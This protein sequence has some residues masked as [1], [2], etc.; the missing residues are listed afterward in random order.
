MTPVS[1]VVELLKSLEK[2]TEAENKAEETLYKKF[3]CWAK[4]VIDT[5]TSTNAAA[6]ERIT[7]LET[8]I[9]D[10]EA[11][12]SEFTSERVDLEKALEEI[13]SAIEAATAMREKEHEDF[14]EAEKE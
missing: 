6:S 11:G 4:T 5:K 9:A 14:L 2:Q 1:R 3:V 7:S 12:R 10:I 13:N 8:Y